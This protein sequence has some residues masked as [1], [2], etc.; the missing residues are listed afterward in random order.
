MEMIMGMSI[1]GTGMVWVWLLYG[2]RYRY[3][4]GYRP[5]QYRHFVIDLG[6]MCILCCAETCRAVPCRA[7]PCRAVPCRAVLL[8]HFLLC[9]SMCP[10]P[11]D[12]KNKGLTTRQPDN[13]TCHRASGRTPRLSLPY[14][15]H[16]RTNHCHLSV[17][18]RRRPH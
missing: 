6:M 12:E 13:A 3:G 15:L 8:C 7:V 16:G 9:T 18:T 5:Y 10:H 11:D 17:S 4:Y 1:V 2:C 14:I